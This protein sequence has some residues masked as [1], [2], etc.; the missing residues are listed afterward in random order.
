[1]SNATRP[2]P[3]FF[4]G[5]RL[6][7]LSEKLRNDQTLRSKVVPTKHRSVPVAPN[8]FLEVKG[9]NGNSYVALMQALPYGVYVARAMHALQTYRVDEPVY[10]GKAYTFSSTYHDGTLKLYPHFMTAPTTVGADQ[11]T[12]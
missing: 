8:F 12:T 9:P 1:M 4:D 2:K 10:D 11:C 6:E 7:D 3:D 5:S